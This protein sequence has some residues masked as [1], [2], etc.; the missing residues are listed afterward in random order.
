MLRVNNVGESF[1]N[2]F[3][4]ELGKLNLQLQ[5]T[6][7]AIEHNTQIIGPFADAFE[8]NVDVANAARKAYLEQ[9]IAATELAGRLKTASESADASST[10][11]VNLIRRGEGAADSFA[12]LDQATLD[13]L[14]SEIDAA[15]SKLAALAA[16]ADEA[17]DAIAKLNA[18]IAAERGDDE[19]AR[20]LKLELEQRQALA[21]VERNLEAARAAGNRDLVRLY[22]EQRG[23]LNELYRLKERNLEADLRGEASGRRTKTALGEMANEAERANRALSGLGGVSLSG[24]QQQTDRL[25]T[26][27]TDLNALL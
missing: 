25:K 21:E 23:K 4:G 20:K 22:E 24:L 6:N 15:K 10:A 9:A 7:Q 26:S 13:R 5:Q 17:R 3:R 11:L 2:N 8:R 19:T 18:E 16:Q 12:L 14:K 1:G 27:I